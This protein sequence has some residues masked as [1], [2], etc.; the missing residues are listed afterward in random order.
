MDQVKNIMRGYKQKAPEGDELFNVISIADE[1]SGEF[2]VK[3][4][5][6]DTLL[7]NRT[8]NKQSNQ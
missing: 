1:K 5:K 6:D 4:I 3:T 7:S 2:S 8:I